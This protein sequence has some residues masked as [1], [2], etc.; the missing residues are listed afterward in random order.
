MFSNDSKDLTEE[1]VTNIE[2]IR[3]ADLI[4]ELGLKSAPNDHPRYGNMLVLLETD[5]IL[6]TLGPDCTSPTTQISASSSL[7]SV[8]Q[9]E[10]TF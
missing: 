2:M 6:I 4:E 3:D 7:S 8:L 10:I 9:S 5:R 1:R